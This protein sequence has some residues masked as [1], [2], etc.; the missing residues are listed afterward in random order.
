MTYDRTQVI[1]KTE[2]HVFRSVHA[3]SFTIGTFPR[4]G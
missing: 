4:F 1:S 3:L 2:D